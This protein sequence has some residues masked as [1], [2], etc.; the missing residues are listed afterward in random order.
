MAEAPCEG[1]RSTVSVVLIVK[2]GEPLIAEALESVFQSTIK[3]AE[4]LVVDG[5]STDRTIDIARSFPC[6]SILEQKSCG[7]A[8]AYNEGIARAKGEFI[9][10]ISYDDVWLP[11][12]LDIQ[13]GHMLRHPHLLCT[14]AMVEHVLAPGAAVPPG[15]R[16][17]L[18]DR[19]YPG[20]LMET[21]VAHRR[22]FT[23]VG[24]FDPDFS[25]AEDTDWFAR[26]RD[27]GVKMA[28]LPDLLLRKRIHGANA[29]LTDP[30]S[31][32]LLLLRAMQRSVARKRARTGGVGDA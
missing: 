18:L 27:A 13:I 24:G 12:K 23:S 7:I 1:E 3:P 8:G 28:L 29:S 15:F 32:A 22:V 30:R 5:G 4:I 6:V 26:A 10:F 11:G 9:A 21:L 16:R 19:P 31:N 14:V 2:D 17:E 20:M 25:T